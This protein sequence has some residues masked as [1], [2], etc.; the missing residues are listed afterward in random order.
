ML[1]ILERITAGNGEEKDLELLEDLA[2]K[3][4]KS[5]L[6]GLGQTAPN[7]V[8]TTLKY[9]K[10]EYIAH[11]TE[12]RCP[13]HS[14]PALVQYRINPGLCTGCTLCKKQCPAGAISGEP[15]KPHIIDAEKCLKCELCYDVCRVKAVEK[16]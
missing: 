3:I 13:A 15:K 10:D 9:F 6:C 12:K 14:C 5:S 8:L 7:P 4:R 16:I 1:E 2:Y 11:I